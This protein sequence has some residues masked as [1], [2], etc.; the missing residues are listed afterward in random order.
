MS[1]Q[2]KTGI[3]EMFRRDRLDREKFLSSL[4]H[5]NPL[6]DILSPV[7]VGELR[8]SKREINV[9]TFANKSFSAIETVLARQGELDIV[10]IV[11]SDVKLRC[12]DSRKLKGKAFPL[13]HGAKKGIAFSISEGKTGAHEIG[14]LFGLG[15]YSLPCDHWREIFLGCRIIK[16]R[17]IRYV[18]CP[19]G[20][21]KKGF[22]P[23]NLEELRRYI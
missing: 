11:S 12:D 3:I 13:H 21:G 19:M 9:D 6:K 22:H 14:H 17:Y 5:Y 8:V 20:N 10:L 2:L 23:K 1:K 18:M 15:H 16:C 7:Y 4:L